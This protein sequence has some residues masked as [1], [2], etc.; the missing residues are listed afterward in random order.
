MGV[1]LSA[2]MSSVSAE[3]VIRLLIGRVAQASAQELLLECRAVGMMEQ[4]Y[5]ESPLAELLPPFDKGYHLTFELDG[6]N[7][8]IF[9]ILE[10]QGRVLQAGF[11]VLFPR[12]PFFS[13]ARAAYNHARRLIEGHYGLGVPAKFAGASTLNYG[14]EKTLS[15]LSIRRIMGRRMITFRTGNKDFWP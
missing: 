8:A 15:Y 5:S 1:P 3:S 13:G 4:P 10:T 11:S 12:L 9:E 2:I 7:K 6:K 14:D